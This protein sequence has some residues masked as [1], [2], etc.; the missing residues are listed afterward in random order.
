MHRIDVYNDR[1]FVYD[2]LNDQCDE[3]KAMYLFS[4]LFP[5]QYFASFLIK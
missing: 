3:W 1:L 2:K 5:I 4:S